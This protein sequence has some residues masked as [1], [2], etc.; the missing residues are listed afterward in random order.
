[1]WCLVF[2][3]KKNFFKDVGEGEKSEPW[4]HPSY[5]YWANEEGLSPGSKE[6]VGSG[7]KKRSVRGSSFMCCLDMREGRLER[8]R[9]NQGWR[10][11]G[12]RG[13]RKRE[14]QREKVHKHTLEGRK[15]IGEQRN[16]NTTRLE[17]VKSMK[18]TGAGGQK[19]ILATR[20]QLPILL[21]TQC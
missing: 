4:D 15:R 6:V 14:R 3:L 17:K 20:I 11:E 10:K 19:L 13:E 5:E 1:M 16:R 8:K 12:G 2:V 18:K 21:K 7:S 9:T